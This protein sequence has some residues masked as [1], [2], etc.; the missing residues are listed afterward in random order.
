LGCARLNQLIVDQVFL[1][2]FTTGIGQH[3]AVDFNAG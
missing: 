3:F 2:F 1:D